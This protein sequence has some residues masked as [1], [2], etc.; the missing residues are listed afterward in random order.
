MLR[1][2]LILALALTSLPVLASADPLLSTFSGRNFQLS[3][4]TGW[5]GFKDYGS[6]GSAWQGVDIAPAVTLSLHPSFSVGARYAHGI[7]FDSKDG[8]V[9]LADLSAFLRLYPAIGAPV[10]PNRI[11][12]SVGAAWQGASSLKDWSGLATQLSATH[13]FNAHLFGFAKYA[14]AFAWDPAN[15]DRDYFRLGLGA[16]TPLAR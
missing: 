11:D 1:K 9:N 6:T 2:M 4:S 15:T 8:H 3:A 16:G 12:A 10:G 13:F 7:P 5:L 14:H